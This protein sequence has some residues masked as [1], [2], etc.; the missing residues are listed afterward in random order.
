MCNKILMF[1]DVLPALISYIKTKM[2]SRDK[3]CRTLLLH[4]VTEIIMKKSSAPDDGSQ[5]QGVH[6]YLV[7][8]GSDDRLVL[9]T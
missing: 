9:R 3:N 8:F 7:D 2:K 1:Q 5:L 4:H 6:T